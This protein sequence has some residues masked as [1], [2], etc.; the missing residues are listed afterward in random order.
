MAC[1]TY[2]AKTLIGNW[3]EERLNES[4]K[5]IQNT[6]LKNTEYRDYMIK[7]INVKE[8]NE[9]SKKRL[10]FSNKIVKES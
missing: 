7:R 3:L 8:T 6:F 2:S 1:Q 5:P 9:F 4:K 10:M